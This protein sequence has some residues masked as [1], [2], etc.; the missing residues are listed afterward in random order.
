[1][2]HDLDPVCFQ[3]DYFARM[4]GQ[5]ADGVQPEVGEDL[6]AQAAFV[7]ELSLAVGSA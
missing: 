5:Q 3:A 7:L 4:I 2:F 6:G 1:L